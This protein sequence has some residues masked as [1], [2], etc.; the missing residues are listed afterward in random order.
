MLNI[1]YQAARSLYRLHNVGLHHGD[2]KLSN[3]LVDYTEKKALFIDFDG[4]VFL[5]ENLT[6]DT[7]TK[8][9]ISPQ[10]SFN[11]ENF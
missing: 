10:R 8:E 9:Y 3:I 5:S 4:S 7:Y 6:C 2:V 11:D 1:L